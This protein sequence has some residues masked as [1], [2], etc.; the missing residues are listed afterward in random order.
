MKTLII[1]GAGFIGSNLAYHHLKKKDQ[2][3][4]F[5]NFSR[6]GANLNLRWLR[7]SF[8]NIEVVRGD[9]RRDKKKL[10]KAVSKAELIYHMAA[11]V[12]VT[13]SVADP[14]TDFEINAMGTLNVLDSIRRAGN[15]PVLFF[16]STNKVY[17]KMEDLRVVENEK[18]YRFFSLNQGID[19]RRN[20]EFYSPYGCSKGAADQY[21]LDYA[22]IYGLKTVVFRQSCIYGPW[23]FGVED[24][25]WVAWF[26]IAAL[27]GKPITIYGNGKQVRDL[28]YIED[29]V[30]AFELAR[31]NINKVKGQAFNI[32]GG[33]KFTLSIWKEFGPILERLTSKKIKVSYEGFRPGDQ[34]IYISNITKAKESFGWEP[35]VSVN[36]GIARLYRWAVENKNLFKNIF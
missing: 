30:H 14:L 1:G 9:I 12:A 4:L 33:P 36:D 24:Q 32:G 34:L 31:K 2:V 21:V 18:R 7:S 16:A 13:T 5:D 20:L 26:I 11:Q 23:Q 28:L 15:H 19:E 25:G 17:G 22:R 10:L 29:L 27:L 35:K 6:K 3:I 8:P